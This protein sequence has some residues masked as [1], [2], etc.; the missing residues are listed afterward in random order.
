MNR[1]IFTN[2]KIYHH[3]CMVCAAW[4]DGNIVEV[5]IHPAGKADS[6]LHNI[7][8]G[9][10]ETVSEN[11]GGSFVRL[12]PDLKGFFPLNEKDLLIY[13]AGRKKKGP[14]R[15]GDQIMVQVSRDAMKGKL[16]ALTANLNFAGRY[17]VLTAG[18][19]TLGVSNKLP[20]RERYFLSQWLIEAAPEDRDYGIVVRTNAAGAPWEELYRELEE[21]KEVF[22]RVTDKG[23]SR[24]PCSLLYESPPEYLSM[25]RDFPQT[26]LEEIITDD[27][28]VYEKAKSYLHDS[29][30]EQESK[31]HLYHDDLLPLRSLYCL[32]QALDEIQHEKV[33]LRSGGFL[34]IQQTEAFVTIDV[35]SGK[36]SGRK[37][38]EETYMKI[39]LEAAE[40]VVRQVRLRNLSGIIL[41]DFI[42]LEEPEHQQELFRVLEKLLKKDPLRGRAVDFTPL[43]ICEMTRKKVRRPVL[44][45][46]KEIR[47]MEEE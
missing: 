22:F 13:G 45:D 24:T 7:Y 30:P 39:N 21:L 46:I 20:P 35:N 38:V 31:L 9:Q 47:G 37:K 19:K 14:L 27:P 36:Y 44:E 28:K 2:M 25:L 10:V 29:A 4:E 18:N 43:N 34:V 33:W 3:P 23:R 12:S 11:I 8:L 42:N 15:P 32:E 17:L 41:V 40:E 5:R 1:L 26:N 6:V 16:P